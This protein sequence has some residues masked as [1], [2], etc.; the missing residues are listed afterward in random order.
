MADLNWSGKIP[1]DREWLMIVVIGKMR[2]SRQDLRRWVGIESRVQVASEE[3]RIAERT[4]S[5]AARENVDREGGGNGGGES[6]EQAALLVGFREAQSLVILSPK[7][8]RKEEA[9][10]AW[11]LLVGRRGGVLR[12]RRV[13]G[14]PKLFR[15]VA[16]LSYE[17]AVVR[18]AGCSDE[19]GDCLSL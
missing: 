18:T 6:G 9:S 10:W 7:N 4:S 17:I 5:T 15:L 3:E 14:R 19:L 11:S 2:A 13:K 1:S 16:E 8:L 12:E